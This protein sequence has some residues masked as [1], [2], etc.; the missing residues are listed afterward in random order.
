MDD[1]SK[2]NLFNNMHILKPHYDF[3]GK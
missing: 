1:K 3:V 2:E